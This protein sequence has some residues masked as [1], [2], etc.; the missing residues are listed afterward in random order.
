M[1]WG[2]SGRLVKKYGIQGDLREELYAAAE[3]WAAALGGRDFM[4]GTSPN[5]ADLA[6][7]GVCRSITGFDTFMDLMHQTSISTWYERMFKAVGDSSVISDPLHV[8]KELTQ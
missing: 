6:V 4:G 5:L 3:E 1:M 2:I 8:K 7:F